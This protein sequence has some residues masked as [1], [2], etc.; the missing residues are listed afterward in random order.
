MRAERETVAAERTAEGLRAGRAIRSDADRDA[1]VSSPKRKRMR[2]RSRPVAAGGGATSTPAAYALDPQLYTLLRSL[3]TVGEV[4]G[5][6]TRLILR[7]DAAPFNVLVQGPPGADP[8]TAPSQL[9]PAPATGA[10]M[11]PPVV[12]LLGA[13]RVG[14]ER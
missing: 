4:V 11:P 10:P 5:P 12:G 1:R 7:T 14:A 2:R 6:H 13:D 8:K 3:D 9:P